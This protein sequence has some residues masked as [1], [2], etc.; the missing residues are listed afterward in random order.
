MKI[1]ISKSQTSNLDNYINWL[2]AARADVDVIEFAG[3]NDIEARMLLRTCDGLLL[4]G[5]PDVDP[6]RYNKESLRS[7]CVMDPERDAMELA[8][9][10]EAG[11]LR[12]PILGICRGLQIL[13]VAHGGTLI[14]DIPTQHTTTVEHRQNAESKIDAVHDVELQPGSILR[15]HVRSF[16]GIVN[17]AHHQCIDALADVFS[18]AALSPDGIIEGIEWNDA[19]IGGKPFL[20]AVQWHP[21]RLEYSNPMSLPIAEHFL[22]EAD[23]YNVLVKPSMG[24]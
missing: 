1:A 7:L 9:I 11:K 23:A 8:L 10:E 2:T 21:E 5:G 14:A 18:I 13:N 20:V 17:S 12:M 24:L 15:H 4:S 3:L 16:D 6:V 22:H 19:S